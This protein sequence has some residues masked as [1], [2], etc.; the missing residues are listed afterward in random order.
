MNRFDLYTA[1]SKCM[2]LFF[3]NFDIGRTDDVKLQEYQVKRMS[4]ICSFCL[5]SIL[6]GE[7]DSHGFAI[8]RRC[9]LK[10]S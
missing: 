4:C 9:Y 2:T 1:E 10:S 3:R 5:N 7:Y 6:S 8:A